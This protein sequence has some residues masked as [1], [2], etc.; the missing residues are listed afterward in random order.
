MAV[1]ATELFDSRRIMSGSRPGAEL[2]YT[3]VGTDD[4]F[5]AHEALRAASPTM[6]DLFGVG[7]IQLPR[8]LL[9]VEPVAP[10]EWLGTVQYTLGGRRQPDEDGKVFEFDTGGATQ[11]ITQSQE[12]VATTAPIGKTAPNHKG[13]IGWTPDYVEGTDIAIPQFNWSET[14]RFSAAVVGT[15]FRRNLF[16]LTGTVNDSAWRGEFDAG[17]VLF[18]GASGRRRG[19]DDWEITFSFSGLPNAS[20]L[21]IPGTA[22]QPFAVKEGW[23]Y[24]WVQYED[25]VDEATKALVKVPRA[26]YIERVYRRSNFGLLPI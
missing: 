4:D 3:I 5:E 13:A 6:Y 22:L 24:L 7:L 9:A 12:T 2:R 8:D 26:A 16:E 21:E 17:E 11:H 10:L 19:T 18:L 1:T 20:P 25:E 14:H 23:D 15:A